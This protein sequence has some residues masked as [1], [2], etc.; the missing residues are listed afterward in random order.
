MAA[1]YGIMRVLL[2]VLACIVLASA[3]AIREEDEIL[4]INQTLPILVGH[5][6]NN[7]L[8]SSAAAAV[9]HE[10][11]EFMN[12]IDHAKPGCVP[13]NQIVTFDHKT[14]LLTPQHTSKCTKK[15]HHEYILA[16]PHPRYK[17]SELVK[18]RPLDGPTVINTE[19]SPEKLVGSVHVKVRCVCNGRPMPLTT[20]RNTVLADYQLNAVKPP[21]EDRVPL[22]GER[23]LT[24]RMGGLRNVVVLLHDTLTR[25]RAINYMP[26]YFSKIREMNSMPESERRWTAF[27]MGSYHSSGYN[28]PGNEMPMFAGIGRNYFEW[29]CCGGYFPHDNNPKKKIQWIWN[30]FKQYDIATG[31]GCQ[32]CIDLMS[33]TDGL[34]TVEDQFDYIYYG[35][36]CEGMPGNHFFRLQKNERFCFG[37]EP[38]SFSFIEYIADALRAEEGQRPVFFFTNFLEAHNM[39]LP[40]TARFLEEGTLLGM[41]RFLEERDDTMVIVMGDHGMQYGSWYDTGYGVIDHR[42]PDMQIF[43]PQWWLEGHPDAKAALYQNQHEI[44]TTYDLHATFQHLVHYPNKTLADVKSANILKHMDSKKARSLL[45]PLSNPKTGA[46]RTCD[47]AGLSEDWCLLQPGVVRAMTSKDLGCKV[48]KR[49]M[50]AAL[51]AIN[52]KADRGATCERAS[53]KTEK[54]KRGSVASLHEYEYWRFD[55]DVEP[56]NATFHAEFRL[57]VRTQDPNK[58]KMTDEKFEMT[59]LKQVSSYARF[60]VCRSK[61]VEH[62]FCLCNYGPDASKPEEIDDSNDVETFTPDEPREG[63]HSTSFLVGVAALAMIGLGVTAGVGSY[64]LWKKF[65]VLRTGLG[66]HA[67]SNSGIRLN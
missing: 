27:T 66:G 48:G 58:P 32:A 22:L 9:I 56:Y 14:M 49:M 21:P 20:E 31:W 23:A 46:P 15:C 26:Q 59:L 44:L 37:D 28:T 2:L 29:K 1:R 3:S 39:V 33:Y 45:E 25:T 11:F 64:M 60:E 55:F 63:K 53:L 62:G 17:R 7:D 5:G 43:I 34:R 40:S 41:K 65:A 13:G 4:Y 36:Y 52:A 35:A 54:I 61:E 47:E 16:P 42:L 67:T 38:Y 18:W 19:Y 12:G 8:W 10:S 57:R 24:D 51:A 50:D 30:D 6:A